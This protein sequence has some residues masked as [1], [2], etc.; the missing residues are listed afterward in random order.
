MYLTQLQFSYI[1]ALNFH[2]ELE[3]DT[4]ETICYGENFECF[5][6]R[7]SIINC[8][9]AW[10]IFY[11]LFFWYKFLKLAALRFLNTSIRLVGVFTVYVY[12]HS[13]TNIIALSC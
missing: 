1:P 7:A 2:G 11:N 4:K 10:K 13:S 6:E 3:S 8:L 12:K 9:Y 5:T